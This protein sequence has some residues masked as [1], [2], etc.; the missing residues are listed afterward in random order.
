MAKSKL[1]YINTSGNWT[2]ANTVDSENALINVTIEDTLGNPRVA[3]VTLSNIALAP[4]A[5][6][7]SSN[8]YGPLTTVFNPNNA[9]GGN[10]TES[11]VRVRIIET[12]TNVT[13]FEGR[14]Y[15]LSLI[16]I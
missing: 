5:A 13:L 12:D 14:V 9:G 16:H 8:K 1:Q 11:F 4:F 2:D 15:D 3:K 10:T 7:G 6:G